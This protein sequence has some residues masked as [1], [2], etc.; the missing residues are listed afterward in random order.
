MTN[1]RLLISRILDWV[2]PDRILAR[3]KDEQQE[4]FRHQIEVACNI[5]VSNEKIARAFFTLVE[6]RT[7]DL[8]RLSKA[9]ALLPIDRYEKVNRL[10][11]SMVIEADSNV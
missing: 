6:T 7:W 8:K 2:N 11:I 1:S 9:V 10:L 5:A 4:L 3:A